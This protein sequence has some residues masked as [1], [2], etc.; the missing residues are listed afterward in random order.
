MILNTLEADDIDTKQPK[1][2]LIEETK[3]NITSNLSLQEDED[4]EEYIL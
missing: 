1:K 3:E 4:E 2:I